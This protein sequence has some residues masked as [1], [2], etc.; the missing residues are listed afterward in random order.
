MEKVGLKDLAPNWESIGKPLKRPLKEAVLLSLNIIPDWESHRKNLPPKSDLQI[1]FDYVP[2]LQL[3]I[4]WALEANFLVNLK[5]TKDITENDLVYL[6][7]FVNWAI[8]KQNW[9]MPLEFR[10]LANS[11]ETSQLPTSKK[12]AQTWELKPGKAYP[13]YR[14]ALFQFLEKEHKDGK[15]YPPNAYDFIAKLK[16]DVQANQAPEDIFI[17]SKGIDYKTKDGAIK[18]ADLKTINQAIKNL[19]TRLS[20][21]E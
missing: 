16:K 6:S 13:G 2:R 14:L 4:E 20:E 21:D 19:I 1:N 5:R 18:K 11:S 3:S 12:V 7:E 10:A 8:T 9:E 17:R 15:E